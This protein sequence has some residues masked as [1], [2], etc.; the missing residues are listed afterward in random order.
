MSSV[1]SL[2]LLRDSSALIIGAGALGNEVAKNLAMMGIRLMVIADRDRVEVANLT[3]SVFFRESD[4]GRLKSEVLHE[5]L[6]ELNPDVSVLPIN[7]D[8]QET[9]GLGLVRRVGMIF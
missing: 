1:W 7:G 5:R 2:D 3:R 4:H 6:I 8:L 9:I